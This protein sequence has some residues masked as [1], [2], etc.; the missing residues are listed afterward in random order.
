VRQVVFLVEHSFH[1]MGMRPE[2]L[3]WAFREEGS[4]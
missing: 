1:G 3:C 4:L 2:S